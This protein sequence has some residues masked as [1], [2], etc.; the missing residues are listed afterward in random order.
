MTSCI[1]RGNHADYVSA[2]RMQPR[3][4]PKL[5]ASGGVLWP[6]THPALRDKAGMPTGKPPPPPPA[7]LA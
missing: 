5:H 7:P 3:T 2:P 1:V 4:H 6:H